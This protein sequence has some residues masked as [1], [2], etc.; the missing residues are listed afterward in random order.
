MKQ[1]GSDI[2]SS[3][4]QTFNSQKHFLTQISQEDLVTIDN[5]SSENQKSQRKESKIH[6]KSQSALL[7]EMVEPNIRLSVNEVTLNAKQRI[8]TVRESKA[9]AIERL[10]KEEEQK[11]FEVLQV[12][13]LLEKTIIK[14][15]ELANGRPIVSIEDFEFEDEE[16]QRVVEQRKVIDEAVLKMN[17]DRLLLSQRAGSEYQRKVN[18]RLLERRA[19]RDKYYDAQVDMVA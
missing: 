9:K 7:G 12:L 15:Q 3:Y 14:D 17:A 5:L 18:Q 10:A 4:E 1:R 6:K 16:C 11:K 2:P 13:N 19:Q 8:K